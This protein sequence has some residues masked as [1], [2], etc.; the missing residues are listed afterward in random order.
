MEFIRVEIEAMTASF[1]YPM[2]IVGYHPTYSVPPV[3]TIYGLLS[4]AKGEAVSPSTLRIGYDFTALGNGSDLE[5]IYEYG[6]GSV[7]TPVHFQQ[8]NVIRREFLYNCTLTLYL[9]DLSFEYHLS[10]PQYP[11]VLGRQAD[12]AYV[13]NIT[14]VTLEERDQVTIFNT[15]IPFDGTIPGQ[16]VSLPV[17]FTDEATRKPQYVKTFVILDSPQVI[18]PGL[19]DSERQCGVFIHDYTGF[20]KK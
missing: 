14:R 16:V 13:R 12:L 10:H 6:G 20:G 7:K 5:K 3:S 18:S 11:L 2:F 15:M 19:F 1:R 8:T 4:A 17:S 9:D